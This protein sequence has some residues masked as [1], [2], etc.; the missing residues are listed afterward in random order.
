MESLA[1]RVRG[2][3]VKSPS[4]AEV[5]CGGSLAH[6]GLLGPVE[7]LWL[8]NVNLAPV[9]DPHLASLISCVTGT[10]VMQIIIGCD[11]V[12]VLN[13]GKSR[14]IKYQRLGRDETQALVRALETSVENLYLED[15]TLN[16]KALTKYSGQGKCRL[17]PCVDSEIVENRKKLKTWAE[18]KHWEFCEAS[19]PIL[20]MK[21][22]S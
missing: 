13:S 20:N 9:P 3:I 7:I 8:D 15:V 14:D 5:I 10:F 6:Q 11:L 19:G 22:P 18:R 1:E 2:E 4:L 16:F 17:L 12:T 21:R